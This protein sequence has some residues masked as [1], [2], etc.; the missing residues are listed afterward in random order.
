MA[1][2]KIWEKAK[3]KTQIFLKKDLYKF[4]ITHSLHMVILPHVDL[5]YYYTNT[6]H[7][8][9][10]LSRQLYPKH[11]CI[12]REMIVEVKRDLKSIIFSLFYM[13]S[14]I[15]R[16]LSRTQFKSM[17]VMVW[18][19]VEDVCKDEAV[20]ISGVNKNDTMF[21][22]IFSGVNFSTTKNLHS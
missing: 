19:V 14:L 1:T 9:I 16:E 20:Q 12:I 10:Q 6:L 15:E 17:V 7:L 2:F 5:G 4:I 3:S 13:T 22:C 11:A 8:L 18:H 21:R